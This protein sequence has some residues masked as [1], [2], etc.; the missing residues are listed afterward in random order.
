MSFVTDDPMIFEAFR[1]ESGRLLEELAATGDAEFDRPSP[2]APWTVAELA[3]HVRMTM[4]RLPGMLTGPE[5]EPAS[6]GL[7]SA[8]GYYRA[9]QRFSAAVNTDRI[10]SA[11]GVRRPCPT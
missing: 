11:Q 1:A 9:D 3:Y 8:A 5:P 6:D 4:G 2:C 7:V 10:E